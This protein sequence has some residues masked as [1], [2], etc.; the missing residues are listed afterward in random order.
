MVSIGQ[1]QVSVTPASE[2]PQDGGT[3]QSGINGD[4]PAAGPEESS[5]APLLKKSMI[6]ED[7]KD[8]FWNFDE[9]SEQLNDA[10]AAK[11]AVNDKGG[12]GTQ[13]VNDKGGK[14]TPSP[15]ASPVLSKKETV[16]KVEEKKDAVKPAATTTS[17]KAPVISDTFN[18]VG[19]ANKL[20]SLPVP[21]TVT[22]ATKTL[23][24]FTVTSSGANVTGMRTGTTTTLTTS[25]TMS[26]PNPVSVSGVRSPAGTVE[27]ISEGSNLLAAAS[28]EDRRGSSGTDDGKTVLSDGKKVTGP[29][30][31][32][33]DEDGLEHFVDP[34]TMLTL[35]E[36]RTKI[37]ATY[38]L[39]QL[40]L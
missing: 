25:S 2:K 38:C 22:E 13:S 39:V 21:T 3:T 6:G 19:T 26:N 20:A 36:V 11:N 31:S 1:I 14:G 28:S 12:K 4:N 40:N 18:S 8:D 9:A 30:S 16:K 15:K 17:N 37:S 5:E 24:K 33:V 35:V 27:G 29:G 7:L 34:K 23:G 32:E 10:V